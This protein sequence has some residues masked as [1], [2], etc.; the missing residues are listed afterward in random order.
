MQIHGI[1]TGKIKEE[2]QTNSYKIINFAHNSW[3]T[4]DFISLAKIVNPPIHGQE[5]VFIFLCTQ[6]SYSTAS[7][8]VFQFD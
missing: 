5:A 4:G 1:R 2:K 7:F 6:S 8:S 3:N